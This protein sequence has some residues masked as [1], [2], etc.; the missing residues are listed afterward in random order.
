M[1]EHRKTSNAARKSPLVIDTRELGRRPGCSRPVRRTVPAPVG[2]GLP[3]VI[4]VPVGAELDLDVL[5]ESVVEGVLVTG[6]VSGAAGRG[7]LALP[8]PDHRRGRGRADRA[9]RLPGLDD[10]R[11]HRRR[12]DQRLVDDLIDLE[13]V[14][15]DTVVLALPQAPLCSEDCAGLCP[16]CGAKWADLGP[17]HRHETIDPR[18]AALTERFTGDS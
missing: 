3:E 15:R 1:S 6:T 10:R 17:D 7:V 14:V 4:A 13:P 9:V 5:L 16:G 18:W 12:R 2:L 11:D 8:R